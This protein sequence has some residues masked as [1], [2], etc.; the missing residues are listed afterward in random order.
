M[1]A[2]TGSGHELHVV[3]VHK[4][5]HGLRVHPR[6]FRPLQQMV[7]IMKFWPQV[8]QKAPFGQGMHCQ[9]LIGVQ[10]QLEECCRCITL[11]LICQT[12]NKKK[13]LH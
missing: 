10:M 1:Y 5:G 12:Y 13:G 9:I 3:L 2:C 7:A 8:P 11:I 4:I 6:R